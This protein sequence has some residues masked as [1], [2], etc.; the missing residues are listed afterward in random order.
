MARV[1]VGQRFVRFY[2]DL[3]MALLESSDSRGGAVEQA[4]IIEQLAYR[5]NG[6]RHVR[7]I[8]GQNWYAATWRHWEREF[9]FWSNSKIRRLFRDLRD[10]N[11]VKIEERP[12]TNWYTLD[13]E[14]LALLGVLAGGQ[15][16]QGGGQIEHPSITGQ[17]TEDQRST[18]IGPQHGQNDH[19][20]PA[21]DA[22]EDGQADAGGQQ[23]ALDG[24]QDGKS[25]GEGSEA[26]PPT[27]PRRNLTR[28]VWL[29]FKDTMKPRRAEPDADD[30][31]T[32]NAALKV[33][34]VELCKKA[35]YG[36]AAS[37]WH[38]GRDA[39]TK[40]KKYN[41]L[42]QILKGKRGGKTTGE[43]I[44]MFVEIAEKTERKSGVP[45]AD[46]AR[47]D[48]RKQEV[49]D[50]HAMA[51]DPTVV[52]RGQRAEEWLRQLGITATVE[53]DEKGGIRRPIVRFHQD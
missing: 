45:S 12:Q 47:I 8:N 51:G 26:S 25:G 21:E 36:C 11:L 20:R 9:P 23:L 32:I 7:A 18:P 6:E 46:S 33:R 17:K 5:L 14:E 2:P 37:D 31:K 4:I 41:K 29:V 52:E 16:E 13:L 53:W 40:G 15:D 22:A 42:S 34:D 44:D 50:M 48:R 43:Q 35:I 27:Q 38:M 24:N 49:R 30:L 10:R 28:E 1:V 3:A 39:Q 19:P